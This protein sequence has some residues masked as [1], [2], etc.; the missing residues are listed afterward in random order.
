MIAIPTISA[1]NKNAK[2]TLNA[3]VGT[4]PPPWHDGRRLTTSPKLASGWS[5][6]TWERKAW[7]YRKKADMALLGLLGSCDTKQERSLWEAPA[8]VNHTRNTSSWSTYLP[9]LSP[10]FFLLDDFLFGFFLDFLDLLNWIVLVRHGLVCFC[11]L[12]EMCSTQV[13]NWSLISR[14]LRQ[15]PPAGRLPRSLLCSKWCRRS[16]DARN[17]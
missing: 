13:M 6:F 5:V 4:W 14:C 11:W 17:D 3:Y 16:T 1:H 9:F 2:N 10:P 8:S 12:N 15:F 7:E